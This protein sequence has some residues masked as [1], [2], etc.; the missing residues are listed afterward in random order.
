MSQISA[1]NKNTLDLSTGLA[2][3]GKAAATKVRLLASE[4]H[5]HFH[6][7]MIAS[8]LV[9]I[10]ALIVGGGTYLAT[11]KAAPPKIQ[12]P[13]PTTSPTTQDEVNLLQG[14]D[15]SYMPGATVVDSSLNIVGQGRAIV[16]LNSPDPQ[17]NTAINLYGPVLKPKGAFAIKTE[18]TNIKGSAVVQLYADPPLIYDESRF[19][20]AGVRLTIE[21]AKLSAAVWDGK[22][23]QPFIQKSFTIQ[24]SNQ[25]I[26]QLEAR[27]SSLSII[28]DG[29]KVGDIA[30]K[31]A[32]V[33]A[34]GS[35]WFGYDAT[36]ANDSY[37]V[38]MLTAV[39][40]DGGTLSIND[41]PASQKDIATTVESWQQLAT[42]K[43]PGK[44]IG[45]AMALGPIAAD[46]D[47]SKLAL[48]GWY[49]SMTT[50]NAL[51][52]QFVHPQPDI[53]SFSEGDALVAIAQQHGLNVH[54][55]TLVFGEANPTWMTAAPAS[56]LEQIMKD[57]IAQVVGHYK[58]K[59]TSWDVVNEPLGADYFDGP[60]VLRDDIWEKAMGQQ[61]ISTAFIAARAADPE[62]KLFIN[63][64]GLEA[65]GDRWTGFMSL[66]DN[67]LKNNVP[68]DGVG[69]QA[70]VYQ[71]GDEVNANVLRQHFDQLEALGKKYNHPL[72]ARISEM[73]VYGRN[74]SNQT[75]QFANTLTACMTDPICTTF[76]MWGISEKYGSTS[77]IDDDG[78]MYIGDGLPFD[79]TNKPL[80]AVAQ[81]LLQL[82]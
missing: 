66:M 67:L 27:T 58:G 18:L 1:I 11:H 78:T 26:L 73:D 7:H 74:S 48:G 46:L 23:Q 6:S 64:W 61:Y 50:E 57:H 82:Q 31:K 22:N 9:G 29:T 52:P 12:A 43:Y 16:S 35:T 79:A 45:A 60:L 34:S 44:T 20:K 62:A 15:W 4:A 30:T 21:G 54:G 63:E 36:H 51:K 5:S 75:S 39:G 17:V 38:A 25:H 32:T 71:H 49:G 37:T 68:I 72:L 28:M 76:S 47:Y 56:S 80:N 3:P 19:D 69:F 40:L 41:V 55:H 8:F 53:Y 24:N 81:M 14:H 65:D 13:I 70:H 59:I 10:G 77:W 2:I 42:K 33:F